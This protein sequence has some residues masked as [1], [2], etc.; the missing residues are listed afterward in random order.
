[1]ALATYT[2]VLLSGSSGGTPILVA[3]SS[4]PGTT[5]HTAVSGTTAFDELWLWATN[6]STL[7]TILKVQCGGTGASGLILTTVT[8]SNIQL[9]VPGVPFNNAVR[10][11]AFAATT[12]NINCFGYVNRIQ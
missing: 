12:S 8:A 10:V 11:S 6:V 2:K 9:V 3:S 1:M 5:M 7:D 4:E